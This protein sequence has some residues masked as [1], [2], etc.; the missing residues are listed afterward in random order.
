MG[1]SSFRPSFSRP[2]SGVNNFTKLPICEGI[3]PCKSKFDDNS[4][5]VNLTNSVKLIGNVPVSKLLSQFNDVIV[6]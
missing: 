6:L 1:P 5:K 4:N 2:F 3:V